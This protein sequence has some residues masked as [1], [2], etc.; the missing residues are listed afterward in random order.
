MD[1]DLKLQFFATTTFLGGRSLIVTLYINRKSQ[2]FDP[3]LPVD[4][5]RHLAYPS[6]CLPRHLPLPLPPSPKY[7][8]GILSTLKI[9]TDFN[10]AFK[11]YYITR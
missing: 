7:H 1:F 6:F 5:R 4:K 11:V 2:F 8:V 10:Q 3:S 9:S